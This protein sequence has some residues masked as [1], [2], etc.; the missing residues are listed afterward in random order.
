MCF[1]LI[2]EITRSNSW[3]VA[4]VIYIYDEYKWYFWIT[5]AT[6]ICMTMQFL[7]VTSPKHC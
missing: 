1:L 7:S 3:L 6:E 4:I 2:L 5:A